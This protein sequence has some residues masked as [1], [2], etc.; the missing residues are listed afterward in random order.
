MS[1][2]HE[3]VIIG[4]GDNKKDDN[5]ETLKFTSALG[6][7]LCDIYKVM[8]EINESPLAEKNDFRYVIVFMKETDV[9]KCPSAVVLRRDHE[10]YFIDK[11]K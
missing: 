2:N 7:Y 3:L 8:D 6:K 4:E 1:M 11:T 9:K 5:V 10:N